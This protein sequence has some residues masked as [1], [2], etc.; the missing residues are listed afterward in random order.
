MLLLYKCLYSLMQALK[1]RTRDS[2]Q[3]RNWGDRQTAA[4]DFTCS[5]CGKDCHGLSYC[6]IPYYFICTFQTLFKDETCYNG[7][8]CVWQLGFLPL[9]SVDYTFLFFHNVGISH[10]FSQNLAVLFE[11]IYNTLVQSCIVSPAANTSAKIN[12]SF[13]LPTHVR[14]LTKTTRRSSLEAKAKTPRLYP[15][16]LLVPVLLSSHAFNMAARR[17]LPETFRKL[18]ISKLSTNYREAVETVT[19]PMLKP[20][21]DELLVK[22]RWQISG[23]YPICQ[24]KC[25]AVCLWT[26]L[27]STGLS[28]QINKTT[29]N[30]HHRSVLRYDF[31][32]TPYISLC[33]FENQALWTV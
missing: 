25:L 15:T 12:E 33:T 1:I 5:Q 16:L 30:D 7:H 10:V 28:N 20:G 27:K 19:V 26:P 22:N 32:T 4:S 14:F 23:M 9:S 13:S 29:K 17:Q 31:H 8:Y 2:S 3:Q 24:S 11:L 21:P 6:R 18:V